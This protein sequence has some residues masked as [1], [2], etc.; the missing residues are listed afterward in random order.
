[1]SS[2]SQ[3]YIGNLDDRVTETVLYELF[4]QVAKVKAVRLPK[5]KVTKRH[6]GF[7]FVQFHSPTSAT[8]ALDAMRGV[9][10][11][12]R[13]LKISEASSG[14]NNDDQKTSDQNLDFGPVVF[15]GNLDP[16]IDN[17]TLQST[18]ST[19][20][21]I[22]GHIKIVR[23]EESCQSFIT[24]ETFEAADKAIDGMN[25][26]LLMNRSLRVGFAF[27]EGTRDRHGDA[28]ERQLWELRREHIVDEVIPVRVLE[29]EPKPRASPAP[30]PQPEVNSRASYQN[31]N[32]PG[33]DRSNNFNPG[34]GSRGGYNSGRSRGRGRGNGRGGRGGNQNFQGRDSQFSPYGGAG[35]QNSRGGFRGG[36]SNGRGGYNGGGGYYNSER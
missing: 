34:R 33:G 32:R 18:F 11:Y 13:T 19:F 6:Q 9:V 5:D 35:G 26:R 15:I 7:A 1:M 36:H 3:L 8:Y 20:G 10:M 29:P 16:I 28:V 27:K 25:G 4:V 2:G 22:R 17:G 14:G 30:T 12:E 24:F 31:Y 21:D 23:G